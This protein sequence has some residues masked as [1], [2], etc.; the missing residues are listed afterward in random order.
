MASSPAHLWGTFDAPAGGS[1]TF[2]LG[3]DDDA[4]VFLN[5]QLVV[6][7]GSVH[8]LTIVPTI[9]SGLAI[10]T[11]R[12]DVFFAD[13][14]TVQSG[15]YFDADVTLNPSVPEASTWAMMFAGFGGLG[16][17]AFRRSRKATVSAI[18]A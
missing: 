10:G 13:R 2:N 14:H 16:Y 5:G 3:S 17:A 11:N 12:V 15:L 1:V 6:D 18:G 4:W 8:A 9:V 7:D